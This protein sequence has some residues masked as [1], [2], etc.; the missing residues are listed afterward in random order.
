VFVYNLS[1]GDSV[2]VSFDEWTVPSNP[3]DLHLSFSILY[4]DLNPDNDTISQPLYVRDLIPP[5]IDS[6]VAYHG[7]NA[8]PGIDDDDYVILYFSE[9]TNRP[10]IDN[11]N[12]D[13]VLSLSSGHSW[14]DGF[15]FLGS[16]YW[17]RDGIRLLICLTTYHSPPTVSAGDTITP[18][19]VTVQDLYG[20]P[21]LAPVVLSGSF[22]PPQGVKRD[23]ITLDVRRINRGSLSFSY[24]IPEEGEYEVCVYDVGG[25][26][27]KRIT[28]NEPGCYQEKIKVYPG[29]YFLHLKQGGKVVKARTMVIF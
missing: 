29:V 12:I 22:D 15:G 28:G 8:I 2:V 6:A 3:V 17:D 4:S 5:V 9:P 11:T 26:L 19:G 25:R 10:A 18:D 23:R 14:L 13:S 16:C 20:N 21:C 27:I 1:P 24:D 7:T